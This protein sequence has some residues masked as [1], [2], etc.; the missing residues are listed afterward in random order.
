MQ[1]ELEADI[2]GVEQEGVCWGKGE[3]ALL[4]GSSEGALESDMRVL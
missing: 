3:G 1:W 4:A 2:G